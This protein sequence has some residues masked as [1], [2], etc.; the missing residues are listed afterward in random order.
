MSWRSK[1]S[2]FFLPRLD[3]LASEVVSPLGFVPN[4]PI[5]WRALGGLT[6]ETNS[7]TLLP[8]SLLTIATVFVSIC[9]NQRLMSEKDGIF[10]TVCIGVGNFEI[11]RRKLACYATRRCWL[12]RCSSRRRGRFIWRHQN[13]HHNNDLLTETSTVS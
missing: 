3:L 11:S 8:L 2:E 12:W 4:F 7:L 13:R 5:W 6:P 1:S 9:S 10:S